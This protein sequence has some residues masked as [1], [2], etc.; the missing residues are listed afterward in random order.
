MQLS[1]R[2]FLGNLGMGA[3]AAA[4]SVAWS[5][6]LV[7]AAEA[8]GRG[9]VPASPRIF[10]NSNENA[11]GPSEK[12]LA[13]MREAVPL[14]NRYPDAQADE[15]T[16][17]IAA[18][19]KVKPEQVARGNGSTE[20]LRMAASAFTGPGK[21][22]LAAS[23]TFEALG[24]YA[25][26]HGAELV[27]VPLRKDFAHDLDAMLARTDGSIGLVYLCNPNNPTASLTSHADIE[28]FLRKLPAGVHVLLDEAYHHFVDA[29]DYRSF[30]DAPVVNERLIV[31]RTF[32]KV[33]GLAGMRLGYGVSSPAVI[34]TLER[35]QLL[36][37]N[38]MVAAC[39]GA[40]AL[41]DTAGVAVA[42]RRNAAD[43]A[44]FM[45]QAAARGLKPIPSQANFVM[46][47]TGRRNTEVIEH[48]RNNHVLIGRPFP[49]MNTYVRV[50]LGVPDEMREFWRAW[51]TLPAIQKQ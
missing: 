20:I 6:P 25:R 43:R 35:S 51:D 38:N 46:L 4:V 1:R 13:A 45:K 15:L 42:V 12:V 26:R 30:L 27:T 24:Y 5:G 48:F 32:S 7:D 22:L 31:T 10:L 17:R 9:Y 40:T 34:K 19:H 29:P 37:N 39:C 11:Y 3:T 8:A 36:D 18:F 47:E 2:S 49:P 21:K 44:E 28:A 33:Y 41:E 50:S 16:A 23:P 14:C